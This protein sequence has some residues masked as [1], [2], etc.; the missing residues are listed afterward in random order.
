MDGPNSA[1]S[2]GH[3]PLAQ[4]L[5]LA[6]LSS[7]YSSPQWYSWEQDVLVIIDAYRSLAPGYPCS[8]VDACDHFAHLK[9]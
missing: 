8:L 6:Q 5:T 4:A 1:V 7:H 2:L 3:T 9:S